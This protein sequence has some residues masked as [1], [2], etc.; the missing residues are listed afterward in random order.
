MS[1][2]SFFSI[3]GIYCLLLCAAII[4]LSI[5]FSSIRLSI[6][7]HHLAGLIPAYTFNGRFLPYCGSFGR[8]AHLRKEHP[9][10]V[11]FSLFLNVYL[12]FFFVLFPFAI[13]QFAQQLI[14]L[15]HNRVNLIDIAQFLFVPRDFESAAKIY[16][17]ISLFKSSK[18]AIPHI[19]NGLKAQKR[20]IFLRL[21]HVF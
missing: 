8:F 7:V 20:F 5:Y 14:Y 19:G 18:K 4:A 6:D 1:P 13:F 16:G 11:V 2:L 21:V 15:C 12:C 10:N 3:E 9:K 17:N